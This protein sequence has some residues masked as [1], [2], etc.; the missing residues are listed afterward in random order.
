MTKTKDAKDSKKKKTSKSSENASGRKGEPYVW[1]ILMVVGVLFMFMFVG[2]MFVIG[3][4]SRFS[5]LEFISDEQFRMVDEIHS[6]VVE[7]RDFD[8]DNNR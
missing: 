5:R 7:S 1:F 2:L 4:Q 6:K 3:L 8:V